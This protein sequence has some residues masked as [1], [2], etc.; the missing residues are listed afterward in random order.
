[1]NEQY[2]TISAEILESTYY[3]AMSM[4]DTLGLSWD[5]AID[6]SVYYGST[7]A[8]ED[9]DKE[10]AKRLANDTITS[11]SVNSDGLEGKSSSNLSQKLDD[12][13][14][15]V[16]DDLITIQT[17]M[18]ENVDRTSCDVNLLRIET[19][20]RLDQIDQALNLAI[21][22]LS[23]NLCENVPEGGMER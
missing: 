9:I 7:L 20:N 23:D 18:S 13:Y 17:A 21:K 5:K 15:E 8:Q 19:I 3:R 4:A 11:D 10:I 12:Y 22:A 1:M 6:L 14:Q 16:K 2:I